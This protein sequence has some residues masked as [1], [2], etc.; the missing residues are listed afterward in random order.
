M[1]LY[2]IGVAE[3][4]PDASHQ[5]GHGKA[6]YL[7]ALAEALILILASAWI[8]FEAVTRLQGGGGHVEAA[9]YAIVLMVV[10]LV[11]DAGRVTVSLRVGRRERSPA[12]LAEAWHFGSDLVGTAAVLLGLVL[13]AAGY[14]GADSIAALLVAALVAVAA[15][16]LPC[17]TSTGSMDRAPAGLAG[18]VAA[19]AGGCPG[20]ARGAL[21]AGARGR[22]RELCRRGDRGAPGWR[23]WSAATRRWTWSK[24]RCA[25][26]SGPPR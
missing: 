14:Q 24:L 19:A 22:R 1:T 13:V 10:V 12:I 18:R 9:W 15:T 8:A 17:S 16:G 2:A 23:G 3:R 11:V 26:G 6:Q 7:S 4:P 21:G 25:S 5:Y 20:G